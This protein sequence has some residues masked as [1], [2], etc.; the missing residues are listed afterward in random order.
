MHGHID[1]DVCLYVVDHLCDNV[2]D[3]LEVT[4]RSHRQQRFRDK[5]T[6]MRALQLLKIQC[7]LSEKHVN[8]LRAMV[9]S[10]TANALMVNNVN[11]AINIPGL[12]ATVAA[13]AASLA[14]LS[15]SRASPHPVLAY[16]AENTIEQ[17][18]K[19]PDFNWI[20][21]DCLGCN[22]KYR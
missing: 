6:H 3:H 4:Y 1:K 21:G 5:Y 7:T 15:I 18:T 11:L 12:S 22:R 20:Y 13:N 8:N 2:C 16:Q 17:N 9:S 10:S 14:C 19:I